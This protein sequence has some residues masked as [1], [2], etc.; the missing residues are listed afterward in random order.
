V[1]LPKRSRFP[2]ASPSGQSARAKVRS[3]VLA[4]EYIDQHQRD[5]VFD[6]AHS[7]VDIGAG[8]KHR[9]A[10]RKHELTVDIRRN[11]NSETRLVE[12]QRRSLDATAH[13]PDEQ[14]TMTGTGGLAAVTFRADYIRLAGE[15][16]LAA[17]ISIARRD[18]HESDTQSFESRGAEPL[19]ERGDFR[20]EEDIDALYITITRQVKWLGLQL[21]LR[22]ERARTRITADSMQPL[23]GDAR[24][25]H[26]PSAS[27]A[28]QIDEG[29]SL[30][31]A[32]S[33]RIGR[34]FTY[35][36][37]PRIPTIDPLTRFEGYTHLDPNRTDALTADLNWIATRGSFRLSAFLNRTMH[38]WHQIRTQDDGVLVARFHNI[39]GVRQVG[40]TITITKPAAGRLSGSLNA[41]IF[42]RRTDASNIEPGL[43][44]SSWNW[45]AGTNSAFRLSSSAS[46]TANV[47]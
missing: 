17:G 25:F 14:H 19:S 3:Y 38:P 6:D 20:H 28:W 11:T 36:L 44:R 10:E 35:L 41:G 16:E 33:R 46:A 42:H 34:P 18:S 24:L 7:F 21:G 4:G 37:N 2:S 13:E 9:F 39:A 5:G 30:R 45:S 43:T 29:R 1:S 8:V 23:A 22:T 15:G 40:S 32:Y 47:N 12:S 26:F 27:L 31:L